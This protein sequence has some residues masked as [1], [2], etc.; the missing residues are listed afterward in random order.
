M[1]LRAKIAI[2]LVA[3]LISFLGF[4][5]IASPVAKDVLKIGVHSHPEVVAKV[6]SVRV[7]DC[8]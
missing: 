3:L 1:K 6:V 2:F 5:L 8:C 7:A 4:N